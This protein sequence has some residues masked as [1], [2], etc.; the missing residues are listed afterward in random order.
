MTTIT[1][2]VLPATFAFN[3]EGDG[4]G[5]KK[6]LKQPPDHETYALNLEQAL[7][8]HFKYSEVDY[9]ARCVWNRRAAFEMEQASN[10]KIANGEAENFLTS[11]FA[12][13][14]LEQRTSNRKSHGYVIYVAYRLETDKTEI[15]SVGH[16]FKTHEN[17]IGFLNE[18]GELDGDEN[19]MDDHSS[20]TEEDPEEDEKMLEDMDEKQLSF[21][22]DSLEEE[23]KELKEKIRKLDHGRM[24]IEN[25]LSALEDPSDHQFGKRS[26]S[27]SMG[28]DDYPGKRK[29]ETPN[30]LVTDGIN[31]ETTNANVMITES[32]I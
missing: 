23:Y 30:V 2:D 13:R 14:G 11:A 10:E 3:R 29:H 16:G 1:K 27:A 5:T 8:S 7:V 31:K 20:G 6:Q 18:I 22:M 24:W 9:S 32:E 17:G 15:V 28:H 21:R 25:R 4:N 26:S 12:K 19:V